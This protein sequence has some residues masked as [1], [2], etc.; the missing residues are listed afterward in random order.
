MP[1]KELPEKIQNP[2]SDKFI[3]TW[4]LWKQFRKLE[5]NFQYKSIISEQM[6]MK[7]LV[8]VSEGDEQKAVRIVEQSISRG[9]M[10]FYQLKQP[11]VQNGKSGK[12]SSSTKDKAGSGST[13]RERV[14]AEFNRRNG[15]GQQS[16][17]E[18]YLKAV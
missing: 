13:L 9:W 6:A 8:E 7:R 18:S 15:T 16:G 2:F 11:S 1:V 5:H 17:D 3:D 4:D 14:Q 12:K 10:D